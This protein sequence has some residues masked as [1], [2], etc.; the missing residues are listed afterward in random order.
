MTTLIDRLL[1]KIYRA[2]REC[3]RY[4]TESARLKRARADEKKSR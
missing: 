4:G 2:K 1:S 3:Q